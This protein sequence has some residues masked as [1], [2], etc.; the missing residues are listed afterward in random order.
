MI[1]KQIVLEQWIR[2][3]DYFHCMKVKLEGQ[4]SELQAENEKLKNHIK[5]CVDKIK[6]NGLKG[7]D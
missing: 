4:I 6:V 2:E 7:S 5:R 3:S 1:P